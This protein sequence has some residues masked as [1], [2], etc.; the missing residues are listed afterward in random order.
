[1]YIDLVCVAKQPTFYH[2]IIMWRAT[3]LCVRYGGGIHVFLVYSIKETFVVC[4]VLTHTVVPY[5]HYK[6]SVPNKVKISPYI[7]L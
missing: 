7:S 2:N 1:M 5:K 3:C 4:V 6:S